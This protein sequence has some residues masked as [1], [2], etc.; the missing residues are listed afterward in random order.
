M[1]GGRSDR[2]AVPVRK[3]RKEAPLG[4]GSPSLPLPLTGQWTLDLDF[5]TAT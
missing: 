2:A 4:S 5:E 3:E 1:K